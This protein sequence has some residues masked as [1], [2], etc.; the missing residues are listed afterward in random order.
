MCSWMKI[1]FDYEYIFLHYLN[2]TNQ[3]NEDSIQFHSTAH[4]RYNEQ[5]KQADYCTVPV[6]EVLLLTISYLL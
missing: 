4:V 3:S 1:E 2:I 6:E 5:I